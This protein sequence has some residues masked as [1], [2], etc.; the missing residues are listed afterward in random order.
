MY[1]YFIFLFTIF[2]LFSYFLL[3]CSLR[4]TSPCL[5]SHARRLVLGVGTTTVFLGAPVLTLRDKLIQA[6]KVYTSEQER[7]LPYI[8][9][10]ILDFDLYEF[11]V[12]VI[13]GW[14][15]KRIP[16]RIQFGVC[17]ST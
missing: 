13:S 14:K 5:G 16:F 15:K 17:S 6:S 10:L 12:E 1:F 3:L 4:I 8:Y 11:I 7:R 9:S 2:L